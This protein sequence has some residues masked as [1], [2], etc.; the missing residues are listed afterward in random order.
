MLDAPYIEV[1]QS[2]TPDCGPLDKYLADY[3]SRFGERPFWAGLSEDGKSRT[4]FLV[5]PSSGT[6][7]VA[8]ARIVDGALFACTAAGGTDF[9]PI[10]T[11]R[12]LD[13][14]PE[15]DADGT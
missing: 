4:I 10:P 14:K 13:K 3:H 9:M 5:N 11:Q 8:I 6:W 12:Q 2:Q 7:T 1:Q 15:K